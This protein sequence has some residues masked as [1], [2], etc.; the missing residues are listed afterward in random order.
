MDIRRT[1]FEAHTER[2]QLSDEQKLKHAYE[3][4]K[5]VLPESSFVMMAKAEFG[6]E[7]LEEVIVEMAE[8]PVLPDITQKQ[9]ST[10]DIEAIEKGTIEQSGNE[11]WK[12]YRNGTITASN[13]HRVH[14]RVETLKTR[15]GDATKLV[16]TLQ[17]LNVPSCHCSK[18]W[19]KYGAH[20]KA[21]I[22][23][24]VSEETQSCS[25]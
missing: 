18:I 20:S 19:Q 5:D 24:N 6:S 12:L 17:G 10:A 23:Q 22:C 13:F 2:V 21:K 8:D 3:S 14:T 11:N 7:E 16:E 15:G 1:L 4:L 25:V 9:L